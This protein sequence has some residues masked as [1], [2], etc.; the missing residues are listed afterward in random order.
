MI[1]TFICIVIF[2]WLAVCVAKNDSK[3]NPMQR[4]HIEKEM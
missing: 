3:K 2:V 1:T 4:L